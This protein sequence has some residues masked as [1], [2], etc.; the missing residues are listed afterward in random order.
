MVSEAFR[1]AVH[2]DDWE[3]VNRHW[4]AALAGEPYDVEHRIRVDGEVKWVRERAELE[5]DERG[6]LV[7]GFGTVQD[8]TQRK[9]AELEL[10]EYKTALEAKIK[11]R[12]VQLEAAVA[13]LH[14]LSSVF[15]NSADPI[16]I[17]DLRGTILEVN[18][19][20]ERAYGWTREE[21]I[22]Q[23]ITILFPPDAH[24]WAVNALAACCQGERSRPSNP[25]E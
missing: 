1:A 2:P 20:A 14:Q 23:P 16:I 8:I 21:M 19:E 18:R 5:F 15:L 11:E 24:A 10:H 7:A 22:G 4:V 17:E 3:Q 25:P 12:T 13:Q 9:K 6:E